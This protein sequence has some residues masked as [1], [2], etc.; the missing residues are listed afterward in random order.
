[1]R[2]GARLGRLTSLCALLV[3]VIVIGTSS[4]PTGAA[5]ASKSYVPVTPTRFMDTREGLGGFRLAAGETRAMPVAG[6]APVPPS[7]AIAVAINVTV[8][9]PS[10]GGFLT[11][12]P[13]GV[14]RPVASNLNYVAQETVANLV[15]VGVGSDGSV[16][17]FAQRATDVVV[18][19]VGWFYAGF[20]PVTPARLM[21][22]RHGLGGLVL[23]PHERRDLIV[24][25]QGGLPDAAIGAVALNVTVTA[26]SQAGFLTVWPSDVPQPLASNLNFVAGK[27]TP[28]AV[29]VGVGSGGRIS[30]YNSAG[31]TQVIVDVAGWFAL[32][33]DAITPA[34]IMDTR[35]GLGGIKL[36]PGEVRNLKVT[37]QGDIPDTGAVGAVSL[38]VTVTE[39]TTGGYLTVWPTGLT[40]P[41]ASNVNFAAGQTVANAVPVG[42]GANGQ[43]SIFNSSGDTDVI[44]DV[45]GWYALSDT[46]APRLE[47][48]TI[49]PSSIDTSAGP[50]TI[51]LTAH[52]TDDLAG[53]G[54]GPFGFSDVQFIG[55]GNQQVRASFFDGSRVSG[56]SLDGI[57]RTTVTV[58][59]FAA[60][61]TWNAYDATVVDNVGNRLLLLQPDL[62][63]RGLANSFEQVGAGDAAPPDIKSLSLT[64]TSIDTSTGAQTITVTAHLTDDFSGVSAAHVQFF[65]VAG[66]VAVASLS[67]ADLQSGTSRDGIYTTT[68]TMR[69]YSAPGTWYVDVVTINDFAGNTSSQV[70]SEL[71]ARGLS[72]SFQQAGVGDTTAP[73]LQSLSWT[74]TA[75]NTASAAQQITV[76]ARVT[77][78]LAGI[79]TPSAS[80]VVSF[81]SPSG[82]FL[83]LYLSQRIAGTALDG[84]YSAALT[85]P[86]L[87]ESGVWT[88]SVEVWDQVGNVHNYF[89]SDLSSRGF[90]TTFTN[91]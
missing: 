52:V 53:V 55:P 63:A 79:A 37:G 47:S 88:A 18:D 71:A 64:P 74:P 23:G 48:L 78:D 59:T 33:F 4:L 85:V 76:T 15:I 62:V 91:N 45:T 34:R 40:P 46:T 43:V 70:R 60:K 3:G 22:T 38:N 69:Q 90:P 75:I 67:P 44:V 17:I 57:Y 36:A 9:N 73:V 39:P 72:W 31:N 10:L 66:Q 61:G 87:S 35:E 65:N 89:G 14:G 77:D 86:A 25:R 84:T 19:V 13:S 27:T 5:N 11:V 56:T 30:I 6:R 54:A 41:L 16:S 80:I 42:V 68:M 20:N 2:A 50:Q 49:S 28:N 8:T 21:D 82:Q 51:T 1:M 7:G 83:T 32:G 26:P 12:W 24:Q 81:A 58:P 29:V